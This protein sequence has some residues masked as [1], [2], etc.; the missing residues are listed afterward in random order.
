MNILFVHAAVQMSISDVARGYRSALERQGHNIRDY[1]MHARID[2]HN[3]ATPLDLPPGFNRMASVSRSASETIVCEAMC[4]NAD[5]VVI[6][7]G[8]NVHPISLWLLGKVGIPV[9]VIFTESPYDDESQKRWTDMRDTGSPLQVT[10]FTND[11]YSSMKY[12]WPLLAPAFDPAVH[13]P[14]PPNPSDE[15]DV[16]MVGTGWPERQAMLEAV[17]WDGIN[18]RLYGVW[19]GIAENPDSPLARFYSPLVVNNQLVAEMYASAKICLNFHRA[20]P[21]ALSPNPRVIETAACGAFQLSDPRPDLEALFG[22]SVPVFRN[23]A[24]LEDNIRYYLERTSLREARALEALAKVQD[25][26]FDNRAAA[27]MSALH[28][29]PRQEQLQGA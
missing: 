17:N 18:L 23:A 6:I 27:L 5:L 14:V 11:R 8:L 12:G 16:L 21:D 7:C 19:P 10:M 26:T 29:Q 13:R 4:H 3:R 24:E 15:C 28:I 25:H 20:H 1:F 2:Y 22:A 9:A